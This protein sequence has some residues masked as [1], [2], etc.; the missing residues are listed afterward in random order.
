MS[1]RLMV[2]VL[3]FGLEDGPDDFQR[4]SYMGNP[5]ET[6]RILSDRV[7]RLIYD[8][9]ECGYYAGF[10]P[11]KFLQ[12]EYLYYD[13]LRCWFLFAY[14]LVNSHVMLFCQLLSTSFMELYLL[15]HSLGHWKRHPHQNIDAPS[16]S[17]SVGPYKKNAVVKHRDFTWI[18]IGQHNTCEPGAIFPMLFYFFFSNPGWTQN[19]LLKVQGLVLVSLLAFVTNS[20]HWTVYGIML[21]FNYYIFHQ[22]LY[23]IKEPF[24]DPEIFH[25]YHLYERSFDTGMF[26]FANMIRSRASGMYDLGD[27]SSSNSDEENTL[28]H[29]KSTPNQSA[30]SDSTNETNLRPTA[31]GISAS[32]TQSH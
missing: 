12:S 4:P 9:F 10:V 14:I 6:E 17:Q 1:L 7:K 22:C 8:T 29:P 20:N 18:A 16:W 25:F 2:Y 21:V 3:M 19:L 27:S 28:R 31:A 15:S 11:L 23:C 13:P 24:L 30:M 5:Q 26:P 32:K